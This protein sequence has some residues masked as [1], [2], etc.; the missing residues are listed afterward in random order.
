MT[1]WSDDDIEEFLDNAQE[2]SET[3][4]D[5]LG[6][7]QHLLADDMSLN[8]NRWQTYL[9]VK[10]VPEHLMESCLLDIASDM[11]SGEFF[12]GHIFSNPETEDFV[13]AVG[14][15]EHEFQL[16]GDVQVTVKQKDFFCIRGEIGS[17]LAYVA[18]DATVCYRI[19]QENINSWLEDQRENA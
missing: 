8:L 9:S 19:P 5:A 18:T 4:E 14:H 13:F 6:E 11:L 1:E 10:G 15:Q 17:Y 16:P 7:Y 12:K 3:H 2:Y